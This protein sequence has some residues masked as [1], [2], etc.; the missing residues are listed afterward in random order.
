MEMNEK[1]LA[2]ITNVQEALLLDSLVENYN[3]IQE[4]TKEVTERILGT[5]IETTDDKELNSIAISLLEHIKEL[6]EQELQDIL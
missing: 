4:L 3:N 2:I 5:L 6:N 1:Q